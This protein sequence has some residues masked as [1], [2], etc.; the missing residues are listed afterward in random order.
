MKRLDRLTAFPVALARPASAPAHGFSSGHLPDAHPCCSRLTP[1][2]PSLPKLPAI[3]ALSSCNTLLTVFRILAPSHAVALSQKSKAALDAQLTLMMPQAEAL[4]AACIPS[5][6][7]AERDVYVRAVAATSGLT[8]LASAAARNATQMLPMLATGERPVLTRLGQFERIIF[9]QVYIGDAWKI[10]NDARK[11]AADKSSTSAAGTPA[12]APV[13]APAAS[14]AVDV[15]VD[16][17]ME[18]P[19]GDLHALPGAGGEENGTDEMDVLQVA[20]FAWER[21]ALSTAAWLL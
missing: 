19:D 15:Q 12:A 10:Q 5:L 18:I 16:D 1:Q 14:Q 20:I 2:V 11:A 6:P 7:A 4:S 8:A 3:D 17:T 9:Q 13:A 21:S